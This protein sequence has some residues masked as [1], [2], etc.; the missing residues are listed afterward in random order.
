[1]HATLR[2]R[3]FSD[4]DWLFEWLRLGFAWPFRFSGLTALVAA[5]R[6]FVDRRFG[7]EVP[8]SAD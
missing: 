8:D 3:P 2:A 5:M 1:M 7:E 6:Y 4:K